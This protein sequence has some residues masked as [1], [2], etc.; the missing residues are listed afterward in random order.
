[1]PKGLQRHRRQS[2][3]MGDVGLQYAQTSR[4]LFKW[5]FSISV[6]SAE[7][8]LPGFGGAAHMGI[9]MKV[10]LMTGILILIRVSSASAQSLGGGSVINNSNSINSSG[11]INGVGLSQNSSPV[12]GTH[13]SPNVAATNPGEFV[14][15]TF[16]DYDAA[17]NQG[18]NARHFRPLTVVEA[19][20]LAQQAKA[21]GPA[22]SAIMLEKDAE[23]NL[24]VVQA[25]AQSGAKH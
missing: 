9:R 24:I 1:M 5:L 8:T 11:S 16:E 23:G 4:T 20:R 25:N 3:K 14:P 7:G 15:S 17:L 13:A 6:D 10:L 19:S 21:A 18:E 12:S 2:Q 22:R